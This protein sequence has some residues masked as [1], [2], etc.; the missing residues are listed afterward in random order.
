MTLVS[1]TRIKVLAS[2]EWFTPAYQAGGIVSSLVNQTQHLS[3]HIDFWI[4]CSNRD[5]LHPLPS[6]PR[7]NQWL[8][9]NGHQ[10]MYVSPPFHWEDI[11]NQVQPDVIY[12]NGIFNGPFCRALLKNRVR[13]NIPTVLASHGMLAP[14]AL[15]I[16]SWIKK[17]WLTMNR[18][19][20]NFDG[21]IWHASNEMEAAQIR[22]HF[23]QPIIKVAQNLPP[24]MPTHINELQPGLRFLSV[25][26]IHPI[27][28]YEFA[29]KCLASCANTMCIDITYQLI[30]PLEDKVE[31]S[32]IEQHQ[33]NSLTIEILG[34]K[35]PN[36]LGKYYQ[37][38]QCLL[39]PSLSE[40]FGLVVTEA[41][42]NGLPVIA[43]DHTP[44][45]QY[46]SNAVL[47]CLPL[48]EDVWINSIT[49]QL[50]KSDRHSNIT[51]AQG[52]FSEHLISAEVIRQ[53]L[54]LF[55]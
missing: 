37:N 49:Q 28:N 13:K 40:N 16:K 29:A 24:A 35:S 36:D 32:L 9:K 51:K 3:E 17:P 5:L 42:G 55:S 14:N 21:I 7:L 47:Q 52:F 15:S 33:S 44:W 12:I 10:V 34:E 27:K 31:K 38:A 50:S 25:G 8:K 39:V 41:L 6:N 18:R 53:H 46:P 43:S 1:L 11:I 2:I 54:N 4:V 23:S 45:G 22:A 26:R 20:G 30:G 19:I 48:N